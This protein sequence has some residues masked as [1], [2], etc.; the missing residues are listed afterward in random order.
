M[1]QPEAAIADAELRPKVVQTIRDLLP[2][3]AGRELPE[4]TEDTPL[5]TFDL[6]S[7]SM[8]RL[9]LELEDTLQ[10]QVDIEEFD[11]ADGESI[12]AL[13]TYIAGHSIPAL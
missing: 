13:A 2:G 6:S 4:L 12:G 8:L 11:E 3:A 9:M 1:A 5:A 10:I 7:A